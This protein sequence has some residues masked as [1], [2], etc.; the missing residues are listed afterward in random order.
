M[1]SVPINTRQTFFLSN[2]QERDAKDEEVIT[3]IEK[4][5]NARKVKVRRLERDAMGCI[6]NVIIEVG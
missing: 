5:L 2:H 4:T 1:R 6:M 3:M